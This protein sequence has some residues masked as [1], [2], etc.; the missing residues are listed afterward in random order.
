[1]HLIGAD[2]TVIVA[3]TTHLQD[4]QHRRHPVVQYKKQNIIDR[5]SSFN[6]I[7]KSIVSL[8]L[9]FGKRFMHV[10]RRECVL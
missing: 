1:M 10:A 6:L 2:T 8:N 9:S 7:S 3:G 5:Q 4:R